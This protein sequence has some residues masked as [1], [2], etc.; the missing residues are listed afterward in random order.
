VTTTTHGGV[1]ADGGEAIGAPLA[2]GASTIP[3]TDSGSPGR[4]HPTQ[5]Q[6][7]AQAALTGSATVPHPNAAT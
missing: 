3:A 4:R 7:Q 2:P 5:A 1:G 6:A